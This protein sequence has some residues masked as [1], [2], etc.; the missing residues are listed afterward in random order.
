MGERPNTELDIQNVLPLYLYI[1]HFGTASIDH[2]VETLPTALTSAR[3]R[4]HRQ[5]CDEISFETLKVCFTLQACNVNQEIACFY[6]D[7]SKCRQFYF[8][9]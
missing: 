8:D 3:Y 4:V 1:S 9:K 2:V 5:I 7:I 6:Y